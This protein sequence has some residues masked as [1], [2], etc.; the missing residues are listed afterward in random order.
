MD[1]CVTSCQLKH[2]GFIATR[3]A[4]TDGV[5]LEAAKWARIMEQEGAT[6]FY[7][8]GEL[9]YAPDRSCLVAEAHFKHPLIRDIYRGCFGVNV[10]GRSITREIHAA[11]R[12]L[13]D[14]IYR[15]VDRFKIDFIVVENAITIPLNLP[16][17]IALTEFISE[18][19]MPTIAHHH[20]FFWE[21]QHFK[22]TAAWE[23]LNMA[24]PPHL[25]TIHHVVINS[26]ADNQLSLRTGISGTIIPNV[27]DFANPP[28]PPDRYAADVRQ[29]LGI[30][31]VR[32][33]GSV[34]LKVALVASGACDLYLATT[35][36]KEWDLCAPHALILE[37]GGVLTNLCGEPMVYNKPDVTACKG[38]IA[39]NGLSQTRI[40][41]ALAPFRGQTEG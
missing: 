8:A 21:R 30:R 26:S 34:G 28:L 12:R 5:S 23:Y 14:S 16:L 3:L 36:A 9:A 24:F 40:V 18:T 20:D 7:L 22:T 39:S 33:V 17:G 15:F 29:A 6:C 32:R 27:M 35:V 13:K 1:Y 19:G 31:S 4:G 2:V 11:K 37:A 10:R 41:E 38:L 25:P